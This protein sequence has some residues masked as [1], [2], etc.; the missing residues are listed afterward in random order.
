MIKS[1][2]AL[3]TDENYFDWNYNDD[4]DKI[5][6]LLLLFNVE[7]VRQNGES[8]QWFPFDKFKFD[9]ERKSSWS[10]EHIHA[11]KSQRKGTQEIWRDWLELHLQSL[12]KL[13]DDNSDLISE[14]KKLL[15]LQTLDYGRFEELQ[16][17][18][19]DKFSPEKENEETLNLLPNLALLKC[20]ENSALGNST[21]DVKRNA[22]IKMDMEGEFIPFCT[23]MAFL[24]YYTKSEQNQLHFWAQIDRKAYVEAIDEVLKNYLQKPVAFGKNISV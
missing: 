9:N 3:K 14:I 22:I 20:E 2:I 12:E 1:S 13:K 24:K 19:I 6:R 4:K 16:S 11:V 5:Q 21:F 8:S 18:I 15:A 7:S 10:L 23:K 17:K